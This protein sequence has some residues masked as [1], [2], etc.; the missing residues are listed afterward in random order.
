VA[1]LLRSRG[2]RG[3]LRSQWMARPDK[4]EMGSVVLLDSIGELASVFSLAS[5]AF[6]GGSLFPEGGHNPLE[7]AQYA[8]PIVM[9][10]Y[11]EN[12]RA[13]VGQLLESEA[14]R[15]ATK[16]TLVPV[17]AMLLSDEDEANLMGVRALEVFDSQ[18]GATERAIAAL[19]RLL[20]SDA[21]PT[22]A[23]GP[24]PRSGDPSRTQP[25]TRR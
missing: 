19:L 9:G 8:I 23:A 14:L 24:R 17:L 4:L 21:A 12:F 3:V 20:P 7:P 18:A 5:I 25:G 1:E 16:E 22:P 11:Y 10:P 15:L 2:E 13:I 6:V